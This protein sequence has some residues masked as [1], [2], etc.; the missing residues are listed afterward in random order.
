MASGKEYVRT[1]RAQ[2]DR[3]LLVELPA[4]HRRAQLRERE[5]A[6][7]R[8]RETE[9]EAGAG[10][11]ADAEAEAEA[12]TE[13]WLTQLRRGG[14]DCFACPMLAQLRYT[15]EHWDARTE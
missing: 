5:S 9:A 12:G 1:R 13:G 2:L 11:G 8:D 14:D 6:R 15:R 4:Q 3:S 7:Q 10:A